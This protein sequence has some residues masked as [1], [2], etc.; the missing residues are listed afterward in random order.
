MATLIEHY[1]R[2]NQMAVLQKMG[3]TE[4]DVKE[5]FT[6]PGFSIQNFRLNILREAA[7]GNLKEGTA[8]TSFGQLLRVGVQA[9]AA[10]YFAWAGTETIFQ[11]IVDERPSNK[12]AEFYAPMYGGQL[13]KPV[14][15]SGRYASSYF[16]GT[17]S[18]IINQKFGRLYEFEKELW[19]D[20]KT[21][22]IRQKASEIGQGMRIAQEMWFT[23]RLTGESMTFAEDITVP[24]PQVVGVYAPTS[25]TG[26]YQTALFG[27]IAGV[28]YGNCATTTGVTTKLSQSNIEA[29]S[30][31]MLKARDPMKNLLLTKMDTLIVSVNDMFT[32][33]K[34]INSTLQPSMPAVS[35]Q[36]S[37]TVSA[38]FTG[39]ATGYVN[40][41]NPLMGL[42]KLKVSRYL[43]AYHWYLG[44][45]KKGL[46]M[47]S[48]SP[49]EIIQENPA[50]GESFGR[51]VLVFKSTARWEIDWI[52]GSNYF[53]FRG[54]RP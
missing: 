28:D 32:A 39:G 17:D 35:D 26:V 11:D 54:Y 27:T 41:I 36:G 6:D 14:E 34:L 31:A 50:S 48:R 23:A 33:A 43:P 12:Y 47:Q 5:T 24:Q 45:A 30:I 40:T 13:P 22:Q 18:M 52:T 16:K 9:M 19:D 38:F 49:L 10:D 25:T 37:G 21:G 42:Y 7:E 1:E 4:A 2:Q 46:I 20:D 51:D 3:L 44:Q 8:E 15:R 53:W 29:A